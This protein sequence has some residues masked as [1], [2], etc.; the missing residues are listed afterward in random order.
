M[1]SETRTRSLDSSLISG[2]ATM[3][4]SFCLL[5]PPRSHWKMSENASFSVP[6]V[7]LS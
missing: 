1:L 6:E 2:P 5:C 4:K 3:G 7:A